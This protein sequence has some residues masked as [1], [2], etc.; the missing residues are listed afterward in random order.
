MP[1]AH[2]DRGR[3]A[4]PLPPPGYEWAAFPAGPGFDP[5]G[6]AHDAPGP[7]RWQLPRFSARELATEW[8]WHE[9]SFAWSMNEGLVN[10]SGPTMYFGSDAAVGGQHGAVAEARARLR[11]AAT[12]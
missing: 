10:M 6:V 11:A 1:T 3:V 5:D 2:D 7:W 8:K 9:S 4:M 12:L